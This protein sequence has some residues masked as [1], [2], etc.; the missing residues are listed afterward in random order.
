MQEKETLVEEVKVA[1]IEIADRKH[2]NEMILE[3]K[4]D[5]RKE[6][7]QIQEV[8]KITFICTCGLYHYFHAWFVLLFSRVVCTIIC[9]CGAYHYFHVW[10]VP[11][12]SCMVCNI[13][14]TCGVYQYFHVWFVLLFARVFD[15]II[16]TCGLYHYYQHVHLRHGH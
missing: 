16:C 10:F 9:T 15:P 4:E 1:K 7:L 2:E 12:F 11:L 5:E 14:F 13:I 3:L 6:K 8:H